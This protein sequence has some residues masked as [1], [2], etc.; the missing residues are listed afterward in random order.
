MPFVKINIEEE[1][2]KRRA[3]DPSFRNAWD[4]S[5]EEYE[6]IGEE[7]AKRKRKHNLPMT[8]DEY[9][10]TKVS[11]EMRSEVEREAKKIDKKLKKLNRKK[12]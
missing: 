3:S 6:R 11:P 5:R 4:E 8:F 1:I 10:Q 12:K 7:I 2:E 9:M